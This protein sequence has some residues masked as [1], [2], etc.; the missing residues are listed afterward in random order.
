MKRR[1]AL[2]R[3]IN[4]KYSICTKEDLEHLT[5][6]VCYLNCNGTSLKGIL[7]LGGFTEEEIKKYIKE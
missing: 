5:E 2:K 7:T 6:A 1:E 4:Y 3:V